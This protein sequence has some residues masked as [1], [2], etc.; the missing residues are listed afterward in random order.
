MK[1]IIPNN[2][3]EY[4][5]RADVRQIHVAEQLGFNSADRISKWEKGLTFPHI[6]NLFKMCNVLQVLPH[7]F[8]PDFFIKKESFD[9]PT[10]FFE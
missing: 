2:I 10:S 9:E 1:T 3:R 5:I 7:H 4:R 8:Y 6:T